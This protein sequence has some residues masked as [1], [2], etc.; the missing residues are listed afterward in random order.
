MRR[1]LDLALVLVDDLAVGRRGLGMDRR[2]GQH[3]VDGLDR[4]AALIHL[5]EGLLGVVG[6]DRIARVVDVL[7]DLGHQQ[8]DLAPVLLAERADG[9]ARH[10]GAEAPLGAEGPDDGLGVLGFVAGRVVDER[11]CPHAR[12]VDDREGR[13]GRTTDSHSTSNIDYA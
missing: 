10:L 3:G 12:A 2:L 4:L 1:F 6:V 13:R 7:E 9:P 8:R 5:L 11:C